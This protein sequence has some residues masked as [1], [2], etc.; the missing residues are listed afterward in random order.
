MRLFALLDRLRDWVALL[1][2]LIVSMIT[3]SASNHPSAETFRHS[4]GRPLELLASPVS[5]L[6][7]ATTLWQENAELRKELITMS[8]E[9]NQYRDALLE[10]SRLRRLLGF[11]DRPEFQYLAAEVVSRDPN[12]A[13]SSLTLDK[14]RYD[15]VRVGQAVVTSGG[16][17]GVVHRAGPN[18]STVLLATDRNFAVSA[19]VERTRVDGIVRWSGGYQLQLTEIP[20]NLD[21]KEGDRIVSS[22]LG[23]LI[24]GGIPIGLVEAVKLDDPLFMEVSVDPFVPY[25]R[26][27]EVFVL[28]PR[29]PLLG[30]GNDST[31]VADSLAA[32][33]GGEQ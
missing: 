8:M 6:I 17:A 11:R 1:V 22:G 24:P 4:I 13:F 28:I 5:A 25:S 33:V 18:S 21:V 16:L 29:W 12:P 30:T 10:N 32:T 2:V 9:R 26:L 7:R 3:M 27:E 15:G 31:A 19:R 14:G 20:R 23:G